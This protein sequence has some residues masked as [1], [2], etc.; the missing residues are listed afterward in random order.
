[1]SVIERCVVYGRLGGVV[2]TRSIFTAQI[3]YQGTDDRWAVWSTYVAQIWELVRSYISTVY[4]NE[5]LVFYSRSG[6]DWIES[7][8]HPYTDAGLA[9]GD[10][11]PN[12]SAIVFLGKAVG[13]RLVGRKFWSGVA[14]SATNGNALI[15]AAA[16]AMASA[17]VL[18]VA[19]LTTAQG[20]VLT[21]GIWGK[22]NAFHSF[23]SGVVSTLLGSMRR[24]KPG[25]GI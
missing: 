18:Y 10:Y 5:Q 6:A 13:K 23:S 8:A 4:V 19:P 20:S 17:C 7:G 9:S 21:P 24:R 11:L 16:I 2:A 12:A 3:D 25:L 14:E 22:D 15:T 1:M